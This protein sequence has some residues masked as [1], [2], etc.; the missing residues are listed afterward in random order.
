[1]YCDIAVPLSIASLVTSPEKSIQYECFQRC[2]SASVNV[3]D[4][5]VMTTGEVL[6]S[7]DP[8]SASV[9]P[10]ASPPPWTADAGMAPESSS[11]PSSVIP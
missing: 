7:T 4:S 2:S 11:M 5:G 9:V 3:V 8:P 10:L 1:M 6:S